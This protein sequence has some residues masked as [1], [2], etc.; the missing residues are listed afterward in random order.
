MGWYRQQVVP[1]LLNKAM[2]TKV[3]R[4]V[5]ARV[6]GPLHGDV[7]E[8]GFGSG[9]NAR[10]YP[11]EVTRV[12]AVEP[13]KVAVRI[14]E[15]RIAASP[16]PVEIAGLDGQKLDLRS[17]SF[18]AVLSTWNLCTIPDVAAALGEMLRVLKP[19]GTF[20]FVDHGHAPDPG[21]ARWQAR[22]EPLS[23]RMLGGC[24]PGR[25]ISESIERSGFIVEE[26]DTYYVEGAPKPWGY[27]F[28]GRARKR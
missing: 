22:L 10:Y 9:L 13:S 15:P 16:V 24:H 12:F 6:C 23:T 1:R 4:E 5:R 20:H 11:H 7:V 26:L 19:G 2:D 17:E 21:V 14:A 18:D 25:N 28:E 27:T 3:E 8:I